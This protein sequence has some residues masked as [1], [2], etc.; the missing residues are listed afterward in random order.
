M[1]HH[2]SSSSA[3]IVLM[4][5]LFL[6]M[7]CPTATLMAQTADE[8]VSQQ[9]V[10]DAFARGDYQGALVMLDQQIADGGTAY[11][12]YYN[13]ACAL[14]H[15]ERLDEAEASLIDALNAGFNDF[16]HLRSDPDLINLHNRRTFESIF[17]AARRFAK[18]AAR[19]A[20][21]GWR[22]RF[23]E[24]GYLFEQ[25]EDRRIHYATA[26][27]AYSQSRMREMVDELSDHSIQ[28]LF[29]APPDDY[30]LI[31]IPT[32]EDSKLFFNGQDH[33]GG[34]YEHGRRRLVA[35]TVGSN[36]RHEVIHAFHWGHMDRLRQRHPIWIQEGLAC[37]YEDYEISDEGLLTFIPNKRNNIAV[38]R[39]R[40]GTLMPWKKLFA[41]DMNEF[42]TSNQAPH[43]YPQVRSIFEFITD[44]GKLDQWY[45]AY[46]S[47]FKVDPTGRLAFEQV[48]GQPMASTERAWRLWLVNRPLIPD[49]II[50]GQAALGI[51]FGQ[52]TTN[53]GVKISKVLRRSA[54]ARAGLRPGDVIMSA[55]DQ[56]IRS[57]DELTRFIADCRIGD[58]ITLVIRRGNTYVNQILELMPLKSSSERP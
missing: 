21:E 39:M 49:T 48:F 29:D 18:D 14:A 22:Q 24:A 34:I 9:P 38:R 17:E 36:L 51:R 2:K 28:H 27:D 30:F 5:G 12:L 35:R 23:G 56:P 13:R 53:D 46:V 37:L 1:T 16:T 33:V 58:E 47:G 4:I 15:L 42:M 10:I 55:N 52:H 40:S 26:L 32:P 31:A 11:Q 45:K 19:S 43:L 7:L 6:G 57:T 20:Q 25:D 44:Q 54:A 41:M 3:V 8:E 50:E